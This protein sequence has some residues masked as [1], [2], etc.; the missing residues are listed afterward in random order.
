M[1]KR[2]A[3]KDWQM[4]ATYVEVDAHDQSVE[5]ALTSGGRYI[6]NNFEIF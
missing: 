1:A 5:S 2:D 4:K 3:E 6:T